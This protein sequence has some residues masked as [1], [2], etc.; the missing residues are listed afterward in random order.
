MLAS[1]HS[2]EADMRIT[3]RQEGDCDRLRALIRSEQKAKRRDRFRAV[4]WALEGQEKLEI[5]GR[6]GVAKST[7]ENWVYAYRDGGIEALDPKKAPGAT[8][9]L[10]PEQQEAFRQRMLAG[11]RPEDGVCTLRGLDAVRILETEF[12]TRYS[13]NG[14]YNLLHRLGLSCLSPRPR[15]EKNDPEAMEA[16]RRDAPPFSSACGRNAPERR[17]GCS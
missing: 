7:V 8:P 11:P 9:K 10:T 12:G 5:A 6:L 3:E 16:F 15:H 2:M 4:V 14:A 1:F 17:S 13:L